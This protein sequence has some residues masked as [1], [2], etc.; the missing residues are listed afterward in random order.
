MHIPDGIGLRELMYAVYKHLENE[1]K[2]NICALLNWA[3]G[4]YTYM[5]E[6]DIKHISGLLNGEYSVKRGMGLDMEDVLYK[7]TVTFEEVK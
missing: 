5:H 7:V 3:F 6:D 4:L 1:N 2:H